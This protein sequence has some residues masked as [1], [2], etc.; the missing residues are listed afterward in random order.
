VGQTMS[1]ET[2]PRPCKVLVA[3]DNEDTLDSLA[4]LLS[5]D[6]HSVHTA[7]DGQQTLERAEEHQ[8]DVVLLDIGM[9]G[10]DGY[11]VA[12]R[13]RAQPWGRRI[14]LVALTGWSPDAHPTSSEEAGF[15]S[16]LVKPVDLQLLA[17]VLS[18]AVRRSG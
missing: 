10:M 16:H 12:R 11:E 4:M 18:R 17:A 15:D 5:L 13:I 8:P 9:P 1:N 3:D 2:T 14:T 7:R 6:G